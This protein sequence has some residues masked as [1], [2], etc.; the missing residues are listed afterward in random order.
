MNR[1]RTAYKLLI[2]LSCA[3]ALAAAVFLYF[4]QTVDYDLAIRH[5][6]RD[7]AHARAAV[8]CILL[9]LLSGLTAAILRTRLPIPVAQIPLSPTAT[10]GAACTAFMMLA[11]FILS[12]RTL[13]T[14][15]PILKIAELVLMAL[16]AAYFFLIA[17]REPKGGAFALL[18]LCPMLY[19]ILALLNVYFDTSYAMNS[20]LKSY[21]LVLYISLALFFSAEARAVIKKPS[22]FLYTFFGVC[23]LTMTV[24]LGLSQFVIS[25]YDTVGHG[26]SLIDCVLRIAVALYAAAR[27]LKTDIPAVTPADDNSI[28][29]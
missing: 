11:S 24:A 3:L 22:A 7:S 5:F 20:P 16:A 17:A 19:A 14:G 10:F 29:E 1:T 6:A 23:C 21:G 28:N 27:L 26:F 15:L 12:I 2:A 18:S 4:A 13:S 8:V 9:S 25:L